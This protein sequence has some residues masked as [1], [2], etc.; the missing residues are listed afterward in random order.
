MLD[1]QQFYLLF[2]LSS[3]S[4]INSFP[5]NSLNPRDLIYSN[6]NTSYKQS[7]GHKIILYKLCKLMV[8]F[9]ALFTVF[10]TN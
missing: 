9:Y 6:T 10:I 7:N 2:L 3:N 5:I 8:T 4:D 1:H